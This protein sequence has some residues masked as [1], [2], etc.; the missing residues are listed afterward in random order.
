LWQ[1]LSQIKKPEH[2]NLLVGISAADD[3]GVY[4]LSDDLALIQTVD[5]F[6]P[7]VDDPYT[8]GQ[9]AVANALSDVYAMGGMPLTALNIV[10]FPKRDMDLQVLVDIL[11]GGQDMAEKAEV[12]IVGGHTIDD[13]ELK[14]GLAV[15]GVVHPQRIVRIDTARVGDQL[16]LTKP[17]GLG[18][19]TTALKV[20]GIPDSLYQRVVQVMTTLNREASEI[21]REVG[22][23][24][25]TDV[26]GFGLLGHAYEMA[27]GSGVSLRI[28]SSRVP[29]LEEALLY[30]QKGF[31][32]GGNW[33][34]RSFLKP[35][36]QV[37]KN[38]SDELLTALHDPQ[39]SGGLLIA[40]P[41]RKA[42]ELV[43]R[44]RGKG[45]EHTAVIG[46]VIEKQDKELIVE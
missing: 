43:Q 31:I 22:I 41:A 12:I 24:A 3:A 19:I 11:N 16:V 44:L 5:F 18:L 36:I 2:P 27:Q 13:A 7:I 15:T 29:L 17:L 28:F 26:T 39:T 4:K 8:F 42:P 6:T 9:I 46:E 1:V 35:H 45:L 14:Y 38:I 37:A 40:V 23:H 20:T 32:P 25:C 33:A 21:M 34:N 10:G 30:A